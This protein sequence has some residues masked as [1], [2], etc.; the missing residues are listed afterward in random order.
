[1]AH[2]VLHN[3]LERERRN[4]EVGTLYVVGDLQFVTEA[5]LLELEVGLGLREILVKGAHRRALD[6]VYVLD[7]LFETRM[8]DG[9]ATLVNSLCT[10]YTVTDDGLT[11]DF[12]LREG[13][14]FSNG[15]AL[16]SEDVK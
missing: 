2:G 10:D 4:G 13:V 16:T 15:E 11:Y 3:G 6:C 8:I 12:T 7:R 5:E 9:E 14:L 1:M